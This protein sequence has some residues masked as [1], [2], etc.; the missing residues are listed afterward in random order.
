[1][2]DCAAHHWWWSAAAALESFVRH[3][4]D[5][6]S[7]HDFSCSTA[8]SLRRITALFGKASCI[9]PPSWWRSAAGDTAYRRSQSNAARYS[10]SLC[11]V[12][13]RTII[14]WSTIVASLGGTSQVLQNPPTRVCLLTEFEKVIFSGS[15]TKIGSRGSS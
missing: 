10:R 11:C 3:R 14:Q 15:F 13:L 6:R 7:D 12:A 4:L 8:Y 1:M 2:G 5:D 9:P